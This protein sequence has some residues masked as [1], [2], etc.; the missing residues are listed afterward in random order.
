MSRFGKR[1]G[2]TEHQYV[3]ERLSAYLDG[4]LPPSERSV[5]EHHVG[6]C[7]SCQWDLATL[8]QS[9]QW[10]REL[11]TIP[12]PRAFTIPAPAQP[13]RAARRR[14]TFLPLLQGA[15]ALVALLLFFVVAGDVMFTGLL[16]SFAP[17]PLDQQEQA[18]PAVAATQVVEEALKVEAAV[19]SEAE[20]VIEEAVAEAPRAPEP[21]SAMPT[22]ALLSE[23]AGVAT[24]TPAAEATQVAAGGGQEVKEGE[25]ADETRAAE[26]TP[27]PAAEVT[28]PQPATP[29][30]QLRLT[31]TLGLSSTPGIT[32]VITG[33]L[34]IEIRPTLAAP[35]LAVEDPTA[36]AAV[37][38]TLATAPTPA[39]E[40]TYGDAEPV[41]EA[42]PVPTAIVP[43]PSPKLPAEAAPTTLA[44]VEEPVRPVPVEQEQRGLLSLQ[45]PAVAWLRVTEAVLATTLVLLGVTTIVI[46]LLQRKAR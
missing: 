2:Q 23:R 15:T 14:W 12:L 30:R 21:A 27:A 32:V 25:T 45:V 22:E 43:A 7:Q 20:V 1:I 8:R 40:P 9:V 28:W 6:A 36:S 33:A 5:V 3:A 24:A 10:T 18:V 19:E 13:R 29:T 31:R 16:P 26:L 46:M 34:A 44:R 37:E 17:R 41:V 11:P 39:P 38:P 4:E 42:E 35:S